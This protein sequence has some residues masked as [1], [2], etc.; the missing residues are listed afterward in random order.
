MA[1]ETNAFEWSA[2]Q[3]LDSSFGR[4]IAVPSVDYIE[5]REDF[6]S[7][8][9]V[10]AGT[11]IATVDTQDGVGTPD[12]TSDMARGESDPTL[13]FDGAEA[14]N[15]GVSAGTKLG[16]FIFTHNIIDTRGTNDSGGFEYSNTIN[17]LQ[18]S[19][20]LVA[21]PEPSAWW[22]LLGWVMMFG[23]RAWCKRRVAQVANASSP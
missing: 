14:V 23:F 20:I 2:I 3:L 21:V 12:A 4:L 8:G 22:S 17:E 6:A 1:K 19:G 16:G 13:S 11:K 15:N 10:G 9:W 5:G 18:F 7:D